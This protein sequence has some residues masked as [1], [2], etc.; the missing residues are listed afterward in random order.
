VNPGQPIPGY[1]TGCSYH[2]AQDVLTCVVAVR[3]GD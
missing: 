1:L 2:P 3:Q